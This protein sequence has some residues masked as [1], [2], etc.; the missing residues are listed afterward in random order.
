MARPELDLLE[1]WGSYTN[2]S[3]VQTLHVYTPSGQSLT[4][5][6]QKQTQVDLT[7]EHTLKIVW[8][9]NNTIT[10]YCDGK[11]TLTYNV[12]ANMKN[13]KTG[14]YEYQVWFL[15]LGLGTY[16]GKAPNGAGWF[17]ITDYSFEPVYTRTRQRQH[18]WN[19]NFT[20]GTLPSGS[21]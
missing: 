17:E 16:D 8:S 4:N 13:Y 9:T 1:S 2:N 14:E 18:Y 10:M 3:V 21:F 11:Q 20:D 5:V 15:N 19:G 6:V 12:P 7:K